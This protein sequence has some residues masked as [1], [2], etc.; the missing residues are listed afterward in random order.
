MSALRKNVAS[1]VVTFALVNA[2]TGAAL[3]GATVTTKV[4]LNGTQS[5]GAG[6]VTEL[7]TGQ[8]KYVP[9]QAETN[10]ASVGFCFTATNA[11]PVNIHCFT[12]SQDPTIVQT[13]DAYARLAN[14]IVATGTASAGA[15]GSIT[16]AAHPG[17]TATDNTCRGETITIVSGTGAGQA[18]VISG[19]VQTTK[20]ASVI[21]NWTTNPDATSVYAIVPQGRAT[22]DQW[23][24]AVVNA[25]VSGRVDASAGAIAANA[26]SATAIAADAIT[27]AKIANGAIDNATFAADVGSTAY[28]TNI[29]ALAAD[30][31][32]QNAALATAAN[33]AAAKTVVDAIKLKTDNLPASPSSLDAAGVRTAVGLATANLDTQ[34]GTIAGY[35]DTEVG[36]IYTRIGAPAGASIAAD[37]AATKAVVDLSSTLIGTPILTLADDIAAL[38]T[39]AA[40]ADAV[41]DE[42]T[43]G[44]TTAGTTGK[45]ISDAGAGGTPLDAAGVRAAIGLASNNLDTQL[46][47][48]YNRIGPPTFGNI[49]GDIAANYNILTNIEDGVGVGVAAD[50]AAI[51]AKTDNLPSDPASSTNVTAVYSR[52]GAPAGASV[53]ADIAAVK[54]DTGTINTNTTAAAQRAAVGLAAAN[55]DT[56]LAT[57]DDFLDTEISAIKAKTD[58][59]P[60]SPAA[61]G[62]A[63][64]LAANA[65]NTAAFADG[66]ITEAKIASLA[67]AGKHFD[68]DIQIAEVTGSVGSV[69]A[70][71][72]VGTNNDKTGYTLTSGERNS[73][74]DALLDRADGATTNYTV[75]EALEVLLASLAGKLSGAATATITIR[76]INDTKNVIVATV[77]ASGNRTAVTVTP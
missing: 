66:A 42:A 45:A 56:Q 62:S 1:Q 7:G 20:V 38:P 19:Y 5:A 13:G 54:A 40:N 67:L 28:A 58:N 21:P 65:I 6:T 64:T 47:N 30:K 63:M 53:S 16:L 50:V 76:D 24:S 72:T 23:V 17:G 57:I 75:R 29:I 22:V 46:S 69:T 61:V 39:A 71:V 60:A 25:L 73:V 32:V 44:H 34:L 41:W 49:S 33:L 12:T 4:A 27:A 70:D 77:D 14:L 52:I 48:T 74:A 2:T 55:L 10:G 18:R 59:L 26:I 11:V 31:A 36:A 8:Y 43:S 9:T 35:I 68:N 15:A 3:T 37:I 51:K